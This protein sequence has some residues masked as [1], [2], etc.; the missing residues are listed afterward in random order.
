[1]E[2]LR[3]HSVADNLAKMLGSK[4]KQKSLNCCGFR[5]GWV[6]KNV[7]GNRQLKLTFLLCLAYIHNY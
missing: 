2:L 4:V 6:G 1:M 3:V 5:T 7:W